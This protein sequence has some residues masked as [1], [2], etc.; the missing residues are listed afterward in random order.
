MKKN[1][2]LCDYF[3][4]NLYKENYIIRI[5][6]NPTK[7][8]E[9]IQFLSQFDENKQYSI[10]DIIYFIGINSPELENYLSDVYDKKYNVS[11]K[12]K[13]N[14]PEIISILQSTNK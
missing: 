12:E 14:I 3:K 2:V 1:L 10:Q 4:D 7:N 13:N 9:V 8:N 5:F 6:I 11:R